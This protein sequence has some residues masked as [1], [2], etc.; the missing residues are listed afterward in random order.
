MQMLDLVEQN[1]QLLPTGQM[2]LHCI[3]SLGL[4]TQQGIAK[5]VVFAVSLK[6]LCLQAD[7]FHKARNGRQ[8]GW[9][10]LYRSIN[11]KAGR[12]MHL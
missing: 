10:H 11:H 8:K 5:S 9:R 4:G 12:H 2:S 1:M 3:N 7:N 6:C